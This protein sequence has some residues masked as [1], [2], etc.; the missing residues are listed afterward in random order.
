MKPV[1][2]A[3]GLD[4]PIMLSTESLLHH[5]GFAI[6]FVA[7]A[8]ARRPRTR[9]L[10]A[11]ATVCWAVRAWRETGDMVEAGWSAAV[12]AFSIALL[13]R[14]WLD[15]RGQG[16]APEEQA[17]VGHLVAGVSASRA[18]H[19]IE[20]GVWLSGRPGDVLTREGEKAENL[21]YLAEGEARVE[22]LGQQIGT[23]RAGDLVGELTVLTG[24]PA[25]A[26][27][28]L[29]QPSRFWCARADALKPY[30]AA[31]DDIREALGQ[32]ISEALKAKLRTANRHVAQVGGVEAA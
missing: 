17:L 2:S 3:K 6:L 13:I 14:Y 32:G 31:H 26:T 11:L 12:V 15:R 5:L 19:L 7:V 18:R 9:A 29:T 8:A 27:V 28:V 4:V 10:I 16:L 23:C 1:I 20:Q 21:Y 25:S 30:V 24:E 22:S